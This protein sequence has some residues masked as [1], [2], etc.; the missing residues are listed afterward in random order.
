[1]L[2][3]SMVFKASPRRRLGIRAETKLGVAVALPFLALAGVP[4]P[5]HQGMELRRCLLSFLLPSSSS[6]SGLASS[7]GRGG[8][9]RRQGWAATEEAEAEEGNGSG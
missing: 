2:V 4:V 1:M 5:P 7:G 6:S 3:T 9:R 8:R